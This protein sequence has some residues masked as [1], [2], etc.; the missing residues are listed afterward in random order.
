MVEVRKSRREQNKKYQE[1]NNRGKH[2]K[3]KLQSQFKTSSMDYGKNAIS[4]VN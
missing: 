1:M 2:S 4:L 3:E